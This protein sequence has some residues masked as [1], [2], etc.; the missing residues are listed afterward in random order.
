MSLRQIHPELD[1]FLRVFKRLQALSKEDSDALNR[2]GLS[3]E[4]KDLGNALTGDFEPILTY[5]AERKVRLGQYKKDAIQH[6]CPHDLSPSKALQDAVATRIRLRAQEADREFY[7][8]YINSPGAEATVHR[9]A[10][11][12]DCVDSWYAANYRSRLSASAQEACRRSGAKLSLSLGRK[13]YELALAMRQVAAM[14]RNL[15]LGLDADPGQTE[16]GSS[17][18]HD[19]HQ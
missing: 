14:M 1:A 15:G 7:S 11:L 4:A 5:I 18:S 12:E 3:Q 17:R 10:I 8:Q 16:S 6:I 9:F 13:E 19:G 2:E